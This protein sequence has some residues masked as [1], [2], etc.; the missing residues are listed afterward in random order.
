MKKMNLNGN[1]HNSGNLPNANNPSQHELLCRL[2]R[3]LN[4]HLPE[5]TLVFKG[6]LFLGEYTGVPRYTQDVD[7]SIA[8]GSI[9]ASIRQV[10]TTF[11]EQLVSE[12]VIVSYEVCDEVVEG[13]SGGAKYRDSTNRVLLS[14]DISLIGHIRS[15]V[16]RD[17]EVAG[18]V[19]LSSVE[20]MLADKLTVLYSRKRFRRSKDLFD[21]WQIISTCQIDLEE[22]GKCLAARNLLPLPVDKAPFNEAHYGE[23]KHA[24][25]RLVIRNETTQELMVKPDYDEI[26]SV[27]GKFTI[28]FMEAEV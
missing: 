5:G 28:P 17:T 26:V 21:A 19:R 3:Y 20:Q 13:R 22:L 2:A 18:T 6:G 27:V 8:S 14:V 11:G 7:V 10:L 9:Y 23:L 24:Y 12:G 16:V 1:N 25:D 4:E 15:V